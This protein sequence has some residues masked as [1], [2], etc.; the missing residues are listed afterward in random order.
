[1]MQSENTRK[2]SGVLAASNNGLT[3]VISALLGVAAILTLLY[4]GKL[5]FLIAVSVI[6]L[7]CFYEFGSL[8][9]RSDFN[10][11]I[12]YF[13]G[14]IYLSLIFSLNVTLAFFQLGVFLVLFTLLGTWGFDTAAFYTGTKLG[15]HKILPKISPNK[16]LE[17]LLAGIAAVLLISIFLPD[18]LLPGSVNASLYRAA[19]VLVISAGAFA[20]DVVESAFKRKLEVKDSSAMI[21][22]H[23]GFLDRFDSLIIT[24]PLSLLFFWWVL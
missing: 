3:R 7:L 22:G 13:L 19:W 4:L 8:L 11:I 9:M 12:Y 16:S 10:K 15:R 6:F 18:F 20:G 23:G 5:A 14:F 2:E 17:G 1:M 24:A 21:P